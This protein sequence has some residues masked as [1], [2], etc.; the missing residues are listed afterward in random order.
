MPSTQ[1]DNLFRLIKTL[2]KSEKR[3]F[4]LYAN[5]VG[6]NEIAIFIQLFD[7]LDKQK[8]YDE[9][10][11]F[12]K[13]PSIKRS[14]LSNQKRHLYKQLL[15]S[16][17]LIHI[18][19]NID[20]EIRE[21][22]DFARILYGKGLFHQ[23]L[24]TLERVKSIAKE[25]NQDIL[26]LEIIEFEKLI[27]T[28]HIT[29]S[30]ENRSVAL[31][32][33]AKIRNNIVSNTGK[34]S[35]LALKLYGLY[36]KIGHIKGEKDAFVIEEFFKS[37]LNDIHQENLTFFE[38]IYLYQSYVWYY[39]ILQ[40]FPL[41]FRNAKK[42][43][44]L[45]EANP[46]MKM[47]DP[48]LFMRGLHNL[49][50][51]IF[52]TSYYEKFDEIIDQLESFTLKNKTRF[53]INSEVISFQYI[54]TAKINKHFTEG[55]FTEGV[56]IIPV[57]EEELKKY[58]LHLDSHR[59]L[60][61]YYKM[62]SMYFSSGDNSRAIDYLNDIINYKAGNLREDIQC[63]AR[64]LHLIA[65][66]ELGH[67]NLLDYLVKSVY[68]FLAKMKE[69]NIVQSEILRFLK[70]ELYSDPQRLR[71]AFIKLKD[72]LAPYETHPFERRSFLYLDIISWLESKIDGI[73]VQTVIQKK[74]EERKKRK[75]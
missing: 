17:R 10:G 65:H 67:Y 52:Y 18:A 39:Y 36:V 20:I 31:A 42:W 69:L 60:I 16:L 34:L 15:I 74:F 57:L 47:N 43:V 25:A 1:T 38:K 44:D 75:E 64:I 51:S 35:N 48:D 62:A 66:Y 61:F 49:L 40:N 3:S 22:I 23:S 33:E 37:H 8:K 24:K 11:I 21:Q 55:T 27:E 53:N 73:P 45:F 14:Q 54:Y 2:T 58:S 5:R 32:E 56:K 19:R 6:G 50:N 13:I 28:R 68:R 72:K 4:K 7:V 46:E 41:H 9:E 26:H 63:Y 30:I 71:N 59:I 12:Q 70:R 29:R